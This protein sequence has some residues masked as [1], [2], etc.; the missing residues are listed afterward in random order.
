MVLLSGLMLLVVV[1]TVEAQTTYS[2]TVVDRA[3]H[4]DP[5]AYFEVY[6]I[7]GVEGA[8]LTLVRGE[9]YHFQMVSTPSIHPFYI[10]ESDRGGDI[11]PWTEGVT[12]NYATGN[13]ILTF[14]VPETAPDL[15]YYQCSFH[16]GMGWKLNIINPV[17]AEEGVPAADFNLSV[18]YP[19]PSR[20]GI[21][22]S[23]SMN[24][25][26]DVTVEVFDGLGRR[27]AVLYDG[28]LPNGTS[29]TFE[30]NDARLAGGVYLVRA[31]DGEA[32]VEQR[33]TLV[34]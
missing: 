20:Q 7:D 5:N 1:P 3:N 9:T 32:V 25:A 31:T 17:S 4:P 11:L 2:V 6:A 23:L 24:E 18:A 10:T 14:V 21:S 30:L 27:V 22:I 28:S 34:R 26:R 33:I 12:N 16:F 13:E 29:H 8:E 15:L 19:N